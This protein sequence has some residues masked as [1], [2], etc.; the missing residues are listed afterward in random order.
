M[1]TW[2]A[3]T[4][5]DRTRGTRRQRRRL[6]G[7]HAAC[8]E[9]REVLWSCKEARRSELTR[10]WCSRPGSAMCDSRR[11]DLQQTARV[12]ADRSQRLCNLN[13]SNV[14]EVKSQTTGC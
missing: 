1:L 12:H 8:C 14:L 4:S 5:A 9:G 3:W 11:S 6:T 10:T 2:T 13:L 7:R